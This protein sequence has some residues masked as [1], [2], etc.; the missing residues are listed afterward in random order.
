MKKV[1]VTGGA[2]FIG[3]H[4]VDLLLAGNVAVRVLDNLSS[5]HRDNL[6]DS[7]PLLEFIEGDIKDQ[8][9]VRESLR[10]VSHCLHLAAQVS[11][12]ASLQDPLNSAMQNIIGFLNVQN[13]ARAEGLQRLVFASS[14]A[15]YGEPNQIP[16]PED[17]E[18]TQ[19]SPY[20]LEKQVNEEYADLYHRIHG[21]ST[22]GL[23]Y[24]NVYGP[25]QDPKSPYAGVI[26]LFADRIAENKVLCV[27]GDGKQTRDFIY[28]G[29]VARANIAALDSHVTGACNIGTGKQI[30]LL[31]LI[32]ILSKITGNQCE[33]SF[34]PP[35]E[36]DIRESLAKVEKMNQVIGIKAETTMEQGLSKLL[37]L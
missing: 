18:K 25:R 22:L 13:A 11:V 29:D 21:F 15:I 27:Y 31:E 36:G 14:A 7:H 23:R 28:V 10:G 34:K 33:V 16:L 9:T 5:G 20:G 17:T 30:T 6:P 3:S 19:L 2:G 1:L 35:R 24:F 12:E 4:T 37:C 32:D 26:A 8:E